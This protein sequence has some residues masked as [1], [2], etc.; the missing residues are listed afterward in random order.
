MIGI[1]KITSPTGAIYIGQSKNIE[2][3]ITHYRRVLCKSQFRIYNSLVKHGWD[4]HTFEIIEECTE[5]QLNEREEH[6]VKFFDTFNTD[7]GMN[8]RPGGG[9]HK[10]SE[11]SK[12]RISIGNKGKVRPQHILDALS[13]LHKGKTI[14]EKQRLDHIKFMTGRKASEEARANMRIA[15]QKPRKPDSPETSRRRSEAARKNVSRP[16]QLERM[17]KGREGKIPAGAKTVI[18]LATGVFYDSAT[19]AAK[20]HNIKYDWLKH[21]LNGTRKN[22]TNFMYI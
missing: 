8:L 6:Y 4:S 11:E 1:Y 18:N 22:N 14:S 21:R 10:L 20:C 7:H 9:N 3:R 13:K 17:I 19:E 5:E 15:Q 16:G 2:S 12:R